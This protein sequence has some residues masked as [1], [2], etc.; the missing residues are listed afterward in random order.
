MTNTWCDFQTFSYLRIQMKILLY[1]L[2]LA[3]KPNICDF[4]SKNKNLI[5]DGQHHYH[6]NK[7][8]EMGFLICIAMILF[9]I[10]TEAEIICLLDPITL[11]S[12]QSLYLIMTDNTIVLVIIIEETSHLCLIIKME[13]ID[14]VFWQIVYVYI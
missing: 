3:I 9:L 2:M 14:L 6:Q 11:M 13:F 7:D 10:T 12:L 8:L 1:L 5:Q 4:W